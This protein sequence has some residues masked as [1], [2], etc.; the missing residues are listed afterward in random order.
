MTDDTDARFV[1]DL[2]SYGSPEEPSIEHLAR[3]IITDFTV[4]ET[5]SRA[6]I[7]EDNPI[8]VQ[9]ASASSVSVYDSKNQMLRAYANGSSVNS[10][11]QTLRWT[12]RQELDVLEQIEAR[13]IHA[14]AGRTSYL[15]KLLAQPD[16]FFV[17]AL[18]LS[19]PALR[20]L[21]TYNRSGE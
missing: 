3:V 4:Y 11:V 1:D 20:A 7:P 5:G 16:S 17:E 12:Y 13:G 21:T 19:R 14:A 15:K 2:L 6:T 10:A 8:S 9:L 18:E